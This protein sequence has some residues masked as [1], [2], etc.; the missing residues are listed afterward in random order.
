ME[1]GPLVRLARVAAEAEDIPSKAVGGMVDGASQVLQMMSPGAVWLVAIPPELAHGPGGQ[2]PD[3]GPNVTLFAEVE[4]IR[5][6]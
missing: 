2:Y 6:R 1:A 5:I 3:I 4:F